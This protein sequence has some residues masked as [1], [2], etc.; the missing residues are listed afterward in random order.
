MRADSSLRTAVV[1]TAPSQ[2]NT[3]PTE[4][5]H[6]PSDGVKACFVSA[7]DRRLD[8]MLGSSA[9]R[10]SCFGPVAAKS[11]DAAVL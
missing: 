10:S 3:R 2:Q 5:L 9:H 1:A 7:P 8:A 11:H 4:R 6:S